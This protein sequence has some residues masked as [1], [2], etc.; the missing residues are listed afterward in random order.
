MKNPILSVLVPT[1]PERAMVF[2]DLMRFLEVIP[3]G[4]SPEVEVLAFCD[5]R[6]RTV[7]AK[8]QGLLE[9]ARGEYV[10]FVDDDDAVHAS[11]FERLLPECR[12]GPDVVT[13][14]QSARSDGHVFEVVFDAHAR[15]DEPYVPGK[16]IVLRRRPWHVCAWRRELALQG[17]FKEVNYGEDVAWVNQVAPLARTTLHVDAVLHYYQHSS[18]TSLAPG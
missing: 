16:S 17:V 15:V 9:L 11:Y 10:A 4:A 3:R 7:G 2:Q 6:R 13:F 5:N 1:V 8:R 12:Q 14:R 18:A